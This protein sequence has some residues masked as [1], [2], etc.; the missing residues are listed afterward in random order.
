MFGDLQLPNDGICNARP[1][2]IADVLSQWNDTFIAGPNRERDEVW[3]SHEDA[4]VI[5]VT[6]KV[7]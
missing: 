7:L 1:V 4:C 5:T 3:T 2:P 6:E